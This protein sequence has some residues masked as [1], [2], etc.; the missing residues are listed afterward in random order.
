ML[1]RINP[2]IGCIQEEQLNPLAE[3]SEEQKEYEATRL[4]N[5]IDQLQR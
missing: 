3:M 2:V 4:V 1:V 5:I